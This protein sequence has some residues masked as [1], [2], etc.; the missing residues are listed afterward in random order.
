MQVEKL[1]FQGQPVNECGEK[2]WGPLGFEAG[3]VGV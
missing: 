1:S 3:K 2:S